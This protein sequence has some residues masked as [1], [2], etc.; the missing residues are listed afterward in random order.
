[1]SQ[2]NLPIDLVALLPGLD[3]RETMSALLTRRHKTI[4]VRRIDFELLPHPRRDSGCHQE[5]EE[6]LRPYLR[7]AR[8]A[9]VLFDHFG[10]GQDLRPAVE[11]ESDVERRLNANGWCDRGL[12]VVIEPE[13]ESWVWS[14][15]DVVAKTL[16]WPGGGARLDEWLGNGGYREIGLE[17]RQ[18]KEAFLAALRSAAL[19]K[20]AAIYRKL[21]E[22][23]PVGDCKDRSFQKLRSQLRAWFPVAQQEWALVEDRCVLPRPWRRFIPT[24]VPATALSTR[25]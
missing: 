11:V 5:A 8:H 2:A 4:G 7:R 22:T 13:L 18:P 1:M 25:I 12:A 20:S 6:A 21:A 10:S 14:D 16:S 19:R 15:S 9:L 3:E 23:L 24:R 17:P